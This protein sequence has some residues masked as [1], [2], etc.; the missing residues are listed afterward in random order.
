M[1]RAP[2]QSPNYGGKRHTGR[3]ANVTKL[4]QAN[5]QDALTDRE[6]EAFLATDTELFALHKL[7]RVLEVQYQK[8]CKGDNESAKI[9]LSYGLGTP[10]QR[11][12][13]A[14]KTFSVADEIKAS[15]PGIVVDAV[16]ALPA[17]ES[18]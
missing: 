11:V 10:V 8:A 6:T 5:R 1:A 17:P 2:Y 7:R 16:M 3:P 14:V 18:S 4:A 12:S 9:Y 13:H 15:I